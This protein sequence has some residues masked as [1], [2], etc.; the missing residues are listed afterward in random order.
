[1]IKLSQLGSSLR[2]TPKNE[3]YLDDFQEEILLS[4]QEAIQTKLPFLLKDTKERIWT[5][6]SNGEFII[7]NGHQDNIP[8]LPE[9]IIASD[10]YEDTSGNLWFA[11][12]NQGVYF[13]DASVHSAANSIRLFLSEKPV[14]NICSSDD[15]IF[16]VTDNDLYRFYE[17]QDT[18]YRQNDVDSGV[19]TITFAENKDLLLG[20]DNM[21]LRYH[22]GIRQQYDIQGVS[23][24]IARDT[25]L[26]YGT[27][28]QLKIATFPELLPKDN[29]LNRSITCIFID[30]KGHV[31]IGT[32]NGLYKNTG[33]EENIDYKNRLDA[34]FGHSISGIGQTNDG[35]VW[36][37]T[38]GAGVI[39]LRGNDFIVINL[40]LIHI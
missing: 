9:D 36:I 1:M 28:K 6:K 15:D 24:M 18:F 11:T 16:I 12:Q 30:K 40:S 35:I 37:A 21:I 17:N 8:E 14:R 38:K 23:T 5:A 22:N 20:Y 29:L 26:Y 3:Y 2:K 34:V 19:R 25:I 31:W 7:L 39:G 32:E 4:N 10:M 27:G 33:G 13:L